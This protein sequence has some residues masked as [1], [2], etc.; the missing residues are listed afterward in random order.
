M[1]IIENGRAASL[2]GGYAAQ[3]NTNCVKHDA[4]DIAPA[5]AQL[6]GSISAGPAAEPLPEIA[7][8]L[9]ARFKVEHQECVAAVRKGLVHALAAGD[10]LMEAKRQ[11]GHGRW[12]GFLRDHCE[13]SERSASRYIWLAK[14]RATI[15][16]KSA[17]VADLTVRGA[18]ELLAAPDDDALLQRPEMAEQAANES[19]EIDILDLSIGQIVL[20]K[21]WRIDARIRLKLTGL[22]LPPDLSLEQWLAVGRALGELPLPSS[23]DGG[24]L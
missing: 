2:G 4:A 7:L 23:I 22:E 14:N 20:L 18:I 8:V 6:Q 13:I 17:T 11:V 1:S 21:L 16:S 3:V 5:A 24:R 15:E 9:A 12:L 19:R 10:V